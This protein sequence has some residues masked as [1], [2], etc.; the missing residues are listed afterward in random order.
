MQESPG[1][2]RATKHYIHTQ[3]SSTS[4]S[5]FLLYFTE[6]ITLLVVDINHYY[7]DPL[8]KG[9]STIPDAYK[10]EMFVFQEIT[11][12]MGQCL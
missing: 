2:R 8:D 7:L 1:E 10:A 9:L 4:C 5:V 12:Q 11:V 3:N 6:N